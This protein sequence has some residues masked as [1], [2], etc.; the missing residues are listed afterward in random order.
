MILK[1]LD[2]KNSDQIPV[3]A[4]GVTKSLMTTES[5]H[6][7]NHYGYG[8]KANMNIQ[9]LAAGQSLSW[10]LT[11]G[12]ILFN[13]IKNINLSVL[14]SSVRLEILKGAD[15]TVNTG[16]LVPLMNTNDNAEN[17]PQSE[18]RANP[19]YSGGSVWD[20]L[21][22]YADST[23]QVIGSSSINGSV[24]EELVTKAN[25]TKYILKITN[26]GTDPLQKA[27]LKLFFYE[28]PKGLI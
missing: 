1:C 9:N 10:C 21:E 25:S 13:H 16:S 15:V 6:T 4:D 23:N 12:S 19:T 27:W 8:Y 26:I 17:T 18:I 3:Q 2:T 7:S 22:A 24:N 5:D 14:G 11:A 20:S 28:E